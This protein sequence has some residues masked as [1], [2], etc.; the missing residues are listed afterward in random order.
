MG[1][2]TTLEILWQRRAVI[3]AVFVTFVLVAAILSKVLPKV[4]SASSTLIVVQNGN[5]ATFDAVQA[6]E[7]TARSYSDIIGSTA[8]A[9]L[10]ATRMGSGSTAT[11]VSSAVSVSP[12]AETQLL[13]ITVESKNPAYAQRLANVYAEVVIEYARRNLG[14][15]A[16]ASMALAS[17]ATRPTSPSRPRTSLYVLVAAILGLCLG[18]GAAFLLERLDARVRSADELRRRF[19]HVVLTR[20]PRLGTSTASTFAFRESFGLLRT[21]LQFATPDGMPKLLAI[22][23]PRESEGKTMCVA[24]TAYAMAEAGLRVIIVDA[25]FR[26]SRLQREVLGRDT[27]PLHPGLSEYLQDECGP[28]DAVHDTGRPGLQLV[29]TGSLPENPAAFLAS[30]GLGGALRELTKG[31]DAVLVDTPPMAAGADASTIAARVEGVIVVVNLKRS[32]ERIL[33]DVLRQLA[34]VHAPVLGFV[35][36][37]D[38]SINLAY[39]YQYAAAEAP[40]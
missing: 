8:V 22:T 13:R 29:P 33:N 24:H 19:K 25:D 20:I 5:A 39:D 35:V 3:A 2:R 16:G 15:S 28:E 37:E 40:G 6:A 21:N 26:R 17:P 34:I 12:V 23:S 7:V 4:Y 32:D 38:D 36:N 18:V 9:E 1:D 11:S 30:H 14:S 31:C 10:V 27:Q